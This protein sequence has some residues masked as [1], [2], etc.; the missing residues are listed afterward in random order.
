M[1]QAEHVG[2][3]EEGAEVAVVDVAD[4]APEAVEAEVGRRER[5]KAQTRQA[6][7]DAAWDLFQ[8]QGYAETTIEHITERVD[9]SSRTF[10]RYFP[11]KEAVVF[12]DDE[13]ADKSQLL[14][15]ALGDRPADEPVLESIRHALH[16]LVDELETDPGRALLVGQMCREN[17]S[18][19][20]YRHGAA[21]Q[22]T[23]DVFLDFLRSRLDD[24]M[25]PVVISSALK[26]A[27]G[28]AWD[29][30]VE[31]GQELDMGKLLDQAID[32]LEQGFRA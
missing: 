32:A 9:V 24:P 18:L 2:R 13:G 26:G 25:A 16:T 22:Q 15:D 17:P 8:E 31:S 27:M 11:S 29:Y 20:E 4:D 23:E 12:A 6:L 30:W 5:K 14:A 1:R 3:L 7:I 10:F 19:D 28:A 21:G